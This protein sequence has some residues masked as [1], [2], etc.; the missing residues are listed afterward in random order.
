LGN[1]AVA[2]EA[3]AIS[4]DHVI[5]VLRDWEFERTKDEPLV[6]TVGL[7][8]DDVLTARQL[9]E[10]AIGSYAHLC[11]WL[12]EE[13][14]RNLRSLTPYSFHYAEASA[15]DGE[16]LSVRLVFPELNLDEIDKLNFREIEETM[17][18]WEVL[19]VT[20]FYRI[21]EMVYQDAYTW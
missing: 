5:E 10:Q 2:L 20:N 21:Y 14:V 6:I 19:E 3:N 17:P 12:E 4:V 15:R 7:S 8:I 1:L 9:P 13:L 11:D 18:W 16:G